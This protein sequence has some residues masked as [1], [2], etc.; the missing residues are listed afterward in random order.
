MN[1]FATCSDDMSGIEVA[2]NAMR[3]N[4]E[5]GGEER[6]VSVLFVD[7]IGSTTIAATNTPTAVVALLN[8]FFDVIVDEVDGTA[9]LSTSSRAT[10]P[11]PSSVRR[12]GSTTTRAAHSLRPDRSRSVCAPK[13]LKSMPASASRQVSQLPEMS[14][15]EKDSSTP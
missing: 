6:D 3:Q 4:P 12:T 15:R 8:R 2:A 13:C 10:Q 1:A 5:L 14:V 9:D 7:V 11:L